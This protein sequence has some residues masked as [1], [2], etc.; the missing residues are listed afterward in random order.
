MIFVSNSSE[1]KSLYFFLNLIVFPAPTRVHQTPVGERFLKSR[2]IPDQARALANALK[3][4][5]VKP[6]KKTI[7]KKKSFDANLNEQPLTISNPSSNFVDN[8]DQQLNDTSNDSYESA[9][10]VALTPP[11]AKPPRQNDESG[12][13]SSI[14]INSPPPAK[15]PRHFS[16]Y[17][18]DKHEDFIQQTDTIVKKVLNLVDSFG[19]NPPSSDIETFVVEPTRIA[20]NTDISSTTKSFD[21]KT[22]KPMNI[23]SVSSSDQI[24][25]P[26]IIQLATDLTDNILQRIEKEF[27]EENRLT[28]N[29]QHVLFNKL[30]QLEQQQT[31]RDNTPSFPHP[32]VTTHI[33]PINSTSRPLMFVSFDSA[34]KTIKTVSPLLDII[35]I[36]PKPSFTTSVTVT[37]PPSPIVSSITTITNSDDELNSTSTLIPTDRPKLSHTSSLD[38]NETISYDNTVFLPQNPGNATPAH[39]LLSDYDNL[40]GSYGSLNDDNHPTQITYPPVPPLPSSSE[41]M[42]STASSSTTTIYESL[43]DYPSRSSS[44]TTSPTYISA[45]STFNTGGTTT[46]HRLNSDISDE[47]LVESFSLER[48][49]RGRLHTK[50][51]DVHFSLACLLPFFSSSI[52][53]EK[54]NFI[55]IYLSI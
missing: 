10:P 3:D 28:N 27:D 50:H 8:F 40:R 49:S 53:M 2:I 46:P 39:S 30:S 24:V 9:S 44:T 45:V 18:K 47:D 36:R 6:L 22:A 33:S 21:D 37:S 52:G 5:V 14:E 11:P 41:T 32:I 31:Y 54:A 19:T 23:T 35:T 29:N 1:K 51:G 20:T 48:S 15:P 42:S 12:S 34:P 13:S 7:I 26:E 38:S 25:P 43:D 4:A 16:L 17:R 55:S